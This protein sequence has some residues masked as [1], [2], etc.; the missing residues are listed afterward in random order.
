MAVCKRA[1]ITKDPNQKGLKNR[2][3]DKSRS[4]KSL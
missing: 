4:G 3:N 2:Q 1:A